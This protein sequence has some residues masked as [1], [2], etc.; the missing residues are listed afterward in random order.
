MITHI[1]E[2]GRLFVPVNLKILPFLYGFVAL[3][4]TCPSVRLGFDSDDF[5]HLEKMKYEFG[6]SG[7]LPHLLN[8]LKT[9]LFLYLLMLKKMYLQRIHT[10]GGQIKILKLLFFGL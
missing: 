4:L 6:N 10:S 5:V 7:S 8:T 3:V 9:Y 1:F 2:N